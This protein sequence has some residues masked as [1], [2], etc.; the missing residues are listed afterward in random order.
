MTFRA[1]SVFGPLEASFFRTSI[2][3]S[4]LGPA[5]SQKVDFSTFLDCSDFFTSGGR[6]SSSKYLEIVKRDFVI[7]LRNIV[8]KKLTILR[9]HFYSKV[10]RGKTPPGGDKTM[11]IAKNLK[12]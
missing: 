3:R 2:D 7:F 10:Y 9:L 8:S 1:F 6:F 11:K 4:R 5:K 12:S